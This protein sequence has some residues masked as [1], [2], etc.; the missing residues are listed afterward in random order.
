MHTFKAKRLTGSMA[1]MYKK[2]FFIM[3]VNW[4]IFFPE[5]I[6][7]WNDQKE[8]L[9]ELRLC[10]ILNEIIGSPTPF[11][12]H[13]IYVYLFR[14]FSATQFTFDRHKFL[15][16]FFIG[17][18]MEKEYHSSQNTVDDCE[19]SIQNHILVI[20]SQ[21]TNKKRCKNLKKNQRILRAHIFVRL[22]SINVK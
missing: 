17:W 9:K 21:G 18:T 14:I 4:Y 12:G 15:S 20:F 10:L 8:K 5:W 13:Q 3:K 16:H 22:P 2:C 7:G 6:I 1:K 11:E 19:N